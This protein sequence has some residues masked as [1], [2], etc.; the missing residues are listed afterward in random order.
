M[1]MQRTGR[2]LRTETSRIVGGLLL[3]WGLGSSAFG[4]SIFLTGHDPDY[5]L[6]GP[7][8]TGA[9]DI[10]ETALGFVMNP[11]NNS[12]A[13]K[14]IDRFM[15]VQGGI[16]PPLGN[17]DGGTTLRDIAGITNFDIIN[18]STLDSSFGLLGTTYSAIV[19][20]SDFGGI[21][22]QAELDILN[23]HSGDIMRFLN[24]G[25]GLFAMAESDSFDSLQTSHGLTPNG[26]QFGF[27]PFVKKLDCGQFEDN[28]TLTPFG[29]GLGL[30]TSDINGNF[31]HN[32]FDGSYGL[33]VVDRD[34]TGR[35]VTLAGTGTVTP[36]GVP[37][38]AS[39]ML[40]V[41]GLGALATKARRQRA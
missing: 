25:G 21:F 27:L 1:N 26:G 34:P 2:K 29:A 41:I 31:A 9:K 30:T 38:P 24:A 39:V 22:S 4:S 23:G 11:L 37:E 14:G 19:M 17:V 16:T 40:L 20:G 35:I 8:P 10:I 12:F 3:L 5:H 33:S 18:A 15:F 32:C 36:I 7:N 13:A 28:F 6:I